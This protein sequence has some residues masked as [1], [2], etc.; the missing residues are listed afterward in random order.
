MSRFDFNF[1]CFARYPAIRRLGIFVLTLLLL[2]LPLATPAYWIWGRGNTVT[3]VT[4]VLLYSEF[5][6]LLWF[7]D[8][9]VYQKDQP[10][11]SHGLVGTRANGV[12]LLRGLSFGLLCLI[13][14]FIFEDWLGWLTWQPFTQLS[15]RI[16][17]EGF[18][19]ALGVGFAEEL[20]F[21]G[22]LVDELQWDYSPK[23]ALWTSS[24]L[25]ALLHF[26]KPLAEILRTLPSFPGL[27]LLGLT[28]GWAR[29]SRQGILGL[30]IGLHASLVCGYYIVDV[31]DLVRYTGQVSVW[32]TGVDQNPLAGAMGLLFLSLIALSTRELPRILQRKHNFR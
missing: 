22:W 4:L 28:L 3:L 13:S 18:G 14:L 31:A 8:R 10:F 15:P 32:I 6:V 9:K 29:R 19:V 21:R 30:S 1:T 2:W 11:K 7:W 24:T 25:Y 12:D 16:V 27:L 26:I 20:L 23:V 17:L 5:M